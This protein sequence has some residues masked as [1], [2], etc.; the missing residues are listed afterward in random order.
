MSEL[1]RSS[2]KVTFDLSKPVVR[3][4]LRENGVEPASLRNAERQIHNTYNDFDQR[5]EKR[6]EGF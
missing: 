1:T 3:R 4:I 6:L 5:A 2:D